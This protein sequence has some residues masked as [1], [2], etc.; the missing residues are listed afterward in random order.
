MKF[1][2]I[3]LLLGL[4]VALTVATACGSKGTDADT[5]GGQTTDQEATMPD[6]DTPI[7]EDFGVTPE[8]GR[9]EE[10]TSELQSR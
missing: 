6:A 10:H 5:N 4:T 3:I 7:D 8:D 9:S 1:K 2:K